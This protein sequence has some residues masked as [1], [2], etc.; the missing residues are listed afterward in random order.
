MGRFVSPLYYLLAGL[1][2][3][4]GVLLWRILAFN[5]PEQLVGASGCV[6]GIVG[7]WAGFLLRNRHEPLA[8]RRLQ[9]ILLIVA[10]QT[11]FDLST[12]QIS[13]AA[14]FSGRFVTRP[15]AGIADRAG[16]RWRLPSR[17]NA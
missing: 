7:V 13:M 10:M 16:S 2:S 4:L 12:P 1:G 14:H 17:W 6:M 9:N 11:A 15:R 5:R 8:G 3:S